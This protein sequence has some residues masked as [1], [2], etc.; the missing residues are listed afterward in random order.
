MIEEKVIKMLKAKEWTFADLQ[1]MS[2][3]VE[4][5]TDKL[6]E[7]LSAQEKMK[8]IWEVDTT[9]YRFRSQNNGE[10]EVLFGKLF[11]SVAI[12]TISEKVV[13][14]VKKELMNANVNFNGDDKNEKK[15]NRISERSV[16]RKPSKKRTTDEAEDSV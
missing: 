8:L 10:E 4:E 15:R 2:G 6:Y 13:N 1:N 5:F 12:D 14:I 11:Y 9:P 16:G 3:V 7:E